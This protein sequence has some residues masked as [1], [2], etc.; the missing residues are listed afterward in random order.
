MEE[1]YSC[2]AANVLHDESSD[3]RD[4][5]KRASTAFGV[6]V[7]EYIHAGHTAAAVTSTQCLGGI[8]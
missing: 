3:R 5:E 4:E 8:S 7:L 2:L 1:L 6:S